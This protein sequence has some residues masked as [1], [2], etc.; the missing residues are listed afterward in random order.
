MLTDTEVRRLAARDKRYEV[1][2]EGG[3]SLEVMPSGKKYWRLKIQIQGRL[4][5]RS[6]GRYPAVS[7]KDARA[8]RDEVRLQAAIGK[9]PFAR[10]SGRTFASLAEEWLKVKVIPVMKPVTVR[11]KRSRLDRLILPAIGEMPA[12]GITAADL[13][14]I[15]REIEARNA[16]ELAHRVM[17]LCSQVFRYGVAVGAVD[18]DPAGDL[19]GALVP[20]KRRHH[21]TITDPAE[22]GALMRAIDSLT[23]DR[24][25]CALKLQAYTFVRPGEL[26]HAE[27]TE[28]NLGKMEWRIPGE[29]MKMGKPHVAPLSRQAAEVV[30]EV[31]LYTGGGRYLFPS[32]RTT[33]RP[34]S[35]A[36][37]N[38][39]LR[40]LG[41][42]KEE[43]TGHGFRSMASTILNEHQWNRDWIERQLAHAPV[44]DV[45]AAYNFAEYLPER[46]EM[47]QW[48]ADWLDEQTVGV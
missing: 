11:A 43:F 27:W 21:P 46:R 19:R 1:F 9:D 14:G 40:R 30:R 38:A 20:V 7:L 15:A 47:L 24:V 32:N 17:Q 44:D 31:E 2:D 25:R 6:L 35:D 23:T 34:M 18:R 45:R 16:V 4:Y 33:S 28:F 42:T 36:T 8:A 13:L 10:R 29:K 3:L 39:A 22:I 48:W 12:N 26:R 37:A 5:R 41:Y